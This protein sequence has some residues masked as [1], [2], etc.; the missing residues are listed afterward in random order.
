MC[1]ESVIVE[2][3]RAGLFY[4]LQTGAMSAEVVV[5]DE[6]LP[7]HLLDGSKQHSLRLQ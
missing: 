2:I 3:Q 5:G 6:M 7:Y 1:T 4:D